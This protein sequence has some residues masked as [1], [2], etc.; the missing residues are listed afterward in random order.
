VK[1]YGKKER[2]LGKGVVFATAAAAAAGI[3]Y[4]LY[5]WPASA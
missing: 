2:G 1:R 3:P 4:L 5:V